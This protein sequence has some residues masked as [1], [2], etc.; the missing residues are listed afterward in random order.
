MK[1]IK[2]T[3]RPIFYKLY[4]DDVIYSEDIYNII[5]DLNNLIVGVFNQVQNQ[6]N[7]SYEQEKVKIRQIYFSTLKLKDISNDFLNVVNKK[8]PP[9]YLLDSI[10]PSLENAL[11]INANRTHGFT[12]KSKF[13]ENNDIKDYYSKC[14]AFLHSNYSNKNCLKYSNLTNEDFSCIELHLCIYIDIFQIILSKYNLLPICNYEYMFQCILNSY[15]F[16]YSLNTK[17]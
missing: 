15:T 12:L 10:R 7:A 17:R 3:L 9:E 14:S 11:K 8:V 2:Q 1:Y 5:D 13:I 6:Y 16:K 4:S